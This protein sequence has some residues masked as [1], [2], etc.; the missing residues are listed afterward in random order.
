MTICTRALLTSTMLASTLA[1][2]A[3]LPPDIQV[4]PA[5]GS[6]LEQISEFTINS[7]W[8]EKKSGNDDVAIL[9]NGKSYAVDLD[10]LNFD[11]LKFTLRNP[12]TADGT[13]SVLIAENTFL[14]GWEGDPS[15]IIEFSYTIENGTG[16]GDEPGDDEIQDIVPEGYVFTPPAGSEVAVLSAFTVTATTETFLTQSKRKNHIKINGTE[17]DAISTTEGEMGN[18]LTFT[19]AKPINEPGNYTIY[20]PEGTFYGYSEIDNKPFIVT[21]KVTGG[22]L[23]VPVYFDGEVTSDPVSGSTVK[24]LDK[25]AIKYPKLTSAYAGPESRNIKVTTPEGEV[26]CNYTLTPDPDDF[27]EAHVMWL[28]FNP[29]ITAEGKYAISF[30]AQCF[31]IA[32]YPVNWYTAPFALEFTVSRQEALDQVGE[33]QF[34]GCEE[35]Y[36]ISGMRLTEA[37]TS[38]IF[39]RRRGDTVEKIVVR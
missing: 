20:I 11:T 16:G 24:Q 6:T 37:P 31:E 2:S 3:A 28:E 36:T 32:K 26:D 5:P 17:V 27:N 34:A 1:L 22:E 9:I 39:L 12:I 15:P 25:I 33:D 30:P 4:T 23:P 35:F 13:Y 29:P 19:L 7:G 21:V 8:L 18:A 10:L 38:G 14:M